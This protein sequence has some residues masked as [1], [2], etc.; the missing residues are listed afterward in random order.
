MLIKPLLKVS[1]QFSY[2]F[3]NVIYALL[4]FV[5]F[6]LQRFKFARGFNFGRLLLW[7]LWL[8]W[9]LISF[10]T[11][12]MFLT[13]TIE[14]VVLG[15]WI[16][17]RIGIM[18]ILL[19]ICLLLLILRVVLVAGRGRLFFEMLIPFL[20]FLNVDSSVDF[21]PHFNKQF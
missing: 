8:T 11:L 12:L 2:S 6:F 16:G 17:F 15:L 19:C 9:S 7:S 13:F 1:L 10:M 18:I 3:F 4:F 14:R 5:G 21:C 20:L